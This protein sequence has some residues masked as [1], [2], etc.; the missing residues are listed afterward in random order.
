MSEQFNNKHLLWWILKA[1]DACRAEG[2]RPD[3]LLSETM[4]NNLGAPAWVL[5][6]MREKYEQRS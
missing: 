6:A 4:W 3:T 5:Q 1:V 2:L